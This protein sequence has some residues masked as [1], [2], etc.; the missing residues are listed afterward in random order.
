MNKNRSMSSKIWLREHFRDIYVQ[1]AYKNG[2]RSRAW[3]KLYEID[4]KYSLFKHGMNII[5]LGSSPGSWSQ[6]AI[7]KVNK[8]G[9]CVISFDINN[10]RPIP[11]VYFFQ[12]DILQDEKIY[13]ILNVIKKK[14]I[15]VVMSDISPNITG[16]SS[17]DIPKSLFLNEVAFKIVKNVL[18]KNGFFLVKIF[19]NIQ[20]KNFVNKLRMYFNMVKICKPNASRNRSREIFILAKGFKVSI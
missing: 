19:Q 2:L 4:K 12:H 7:K 10:M 14:K 5:D 15:H 13:C 16:I 3:F 18:S 20:L 1:N 9:G 6:Y 8:K 17:I 11:G